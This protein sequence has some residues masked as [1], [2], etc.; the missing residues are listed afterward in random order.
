MQVR[1]ERPLD[2]IAPAPR[3]AEQQSLVRAFD[4]APRRGAPQPHQPLVLELR[5]PE[6]FV[7]RVRQFRHQTAFELQ[8]EESRQPRVTPSPA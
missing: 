7:E 2:G 1:Q 6:H 8:A 4:F 3:P 5:A